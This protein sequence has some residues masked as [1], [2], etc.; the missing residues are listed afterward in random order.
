MKRLFKTSAT[1][2]LMLL[3]SSS[4]MAQTVQQANKRGVTPEDYYAFQFLSDPRFSP[5]GEQVAYVVTTVDRRQNR[6]SSAIWLTTTDNGASPRQLTASNFTS[7]SPRWRPDGQAI[8]FISAR[9][10]TNEASETVRPQVWL[11]SMSGGEPRRLTNFKNGAGNFQWSP[12]GKRLVCLSRT[13]PSDNRPENRERSDVRHYTRISYKFNDTGWF[14]DKRNHL[15]VV[16]VTSGNS[17][18]ITSGEDWDDADPQWSPDGSRI[19]FVSNRTGKLFDGDRNTDVFVVSAEGGAPSKISDHT[20]PDNS[21]RWSPDGKSIAFVGSIQES[22]HP[23]IF[24]TSSAGDSPSALAVN[25]LDLI[26]ANLAWAESGRALYFESGVKGETHVFRVDLASKAFKQITTGARAVRNFEISDKARKMIFLSNTFKQL[27]DLYVVDLGSEAG[28]GA[29]RRLTSLNE[30]LWKE[31]EM[32]D[33]ERL[34]YKGADGWDVDGF[35]VKPRGWREGVKYPMVLNIHGGPAGMYGVDWYHEFQ[36]YAARG[37][38]VFFTN[39]R[40]S[41]GYGERFERG[42]KNEWGGK[43]YVDV[44]NGVDAVLKKYDWIDREKLGVTGGSYGGFLTNWIVSHTNLFKAAVTLRSVTNFISD[45]GTRDGAYG[46]KR[47]FDGHLFDRFDFYWE[48]S[49]LKYAKNVKT[50]ILILH[51]DNDL[52]VPLEQGEQWFR[53]LKLYGATAEFV[54][55][56][57]EN[58]NLTRTGEPRHLV[59]SLNW[60]VYWFDKY[61][62]DNKAAVPPNAR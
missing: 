1:I 9:P 26:P 57:R 28:E 12:D 22:S 24:V 36:V 27:D 34:T 3:I 19:A 35:F 48:R 2:L 45:E 15:F 21:P 33:V 23:K 13:G 50:P 55:F 61:L 7:N 60:Q 10:L 39:P 42:I 62:N 11:L 46:H 17:K 54:V 44:M 29:G 51:A 59:E 5:G 47:D 53:A 20:E 40:G 49:P 41:T 8:A 16:D 43:D 25:G 31:L 38:A 58:H 37:W 32:M 4:L 6:R 14:D 30:A 56:P 52:R 18:Q